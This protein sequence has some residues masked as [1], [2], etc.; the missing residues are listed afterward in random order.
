MTF[1]LCVET[2]FCAS[3]TRS[4]SMTDYFVLV[5]FL[6]EVTTRLTQFLKKFPDDSLLL[7]GLLNSWSSSIFWDSKEHRLMYTF[8]V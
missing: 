3:R 8:L 4:C 2:M 5:S 1:R 6:A 7:S